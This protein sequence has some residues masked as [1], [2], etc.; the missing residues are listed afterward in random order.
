MVNLWMRRV[1]QH[2][3]IVASHGGQ[4]AAPCQRQLHRMWTNTGSKQRS[5][6][7]VLSQPVI[8]ISKRGFERW[9]TASTDWPIMQRRENHMAVVD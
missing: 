6:G 4:Q 7:S 9:P 2:L 3:N 5:C 1:L 8:T